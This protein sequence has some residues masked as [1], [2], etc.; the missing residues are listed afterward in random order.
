MQI[1]ECRVVA[2]G[3]DEVVIVGRDISDRKFAEIALRES[4]SHKAALIRALPDLIMR[5]HKDGTYLEFHSTESF[6]VFGEAEDFVG[7]HLDKDL[8][9][10]VVEQRMKMINWALETGDIQIYEQEVLVDGKTKLKK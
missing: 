9:P 1:E 6:K 5:I 10:N 7:N 3:E 2:C 8:S 4:E